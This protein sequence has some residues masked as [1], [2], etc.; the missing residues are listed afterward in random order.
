[1]SVL[2]CPDY[3][4]ANPYQSALIDGLED[5]GVRVIPTNG[6]GAF[7]LLGS[8]R[9]RGRPDLL[10]LHWLHR[11]LVA[12]R[13]PRLLAVPLAVRLLLELLVLRIRGVRIVWTVHNLSNHESPTPRTEVAVRS[14]V[15]RLADR[16][17][18]HCDRAAEQIRERYRLPD[19]VGERIAVVPHG[20]YDEWY[21]AGPGRRKARA[22]LGVE[23][24]RPIFLYFGMIRPYKNVPGLIRAFRSI[25]AE[26]RLLVVGN[27]RDAEVEIRVRS[28]SAGDDR[29]RQTLEYVPDEDVPTYFRAA[30]VVVLPFQNVLTSGSAILAMTFGRA[31]IAPRLGCIPGLLGGNGGIIY[32]P[33]VDEALKQA[34][35]T[36]LDQAAN[37]PEMGARNRRVADRL[38]W[39]RIG[40]MTSEVYEQALAPRAPV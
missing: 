7:P 24:D 27:P 4:R 14:L 1:M 31:V 39:E 23:T 12:D 40:S 13:L 30:D 34:L 33:Q 28:A 9:S 5:E 6:A 37:L 21:A 8:Y 25:D 19:H 29:I 32:D 18:V 35:R 3:T 38:D 11:Y 2:M 26:A 10:H 15:A 17:I 16:V 36:A 20:N 22:E